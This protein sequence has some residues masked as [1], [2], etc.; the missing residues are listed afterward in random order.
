MPILQAAMPY[1]L[2]CL[3]HVPLY[4]EMLATGMYLIPFNKYYIRHMFITKDIFLSLP[5]FTASVFLK[6]Q[7]PKNKQKNVF[8]FFTEPILS[9]RGWDK[10]D[11]LPFIRVPGKQEEQNRICMFK[12]VGVTVVSNCC[13]YT[14]LEFCFFRE[15]TLSFQNLPTDSPIPKPQPH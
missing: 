12:P 4:I 7:I 8:I 3:L 2:Y 13:H 11:R 14:A 15:L 1:S 5:L 10:N 6:T 9:S